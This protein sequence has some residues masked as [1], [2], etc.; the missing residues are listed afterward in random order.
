MI[1]ADSRTEGP[2]SIPSQINQHLAH[3]RSFKVVDRTHYIRLETE[4]IA[5]TT[6]IP[7]R[8][9]LVTTLMDLSSSL[10]HLQKTQQT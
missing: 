8:S 2:T 6:K 5:Y 7:Q 1:G 3:T 4:E 9:Q 10:S